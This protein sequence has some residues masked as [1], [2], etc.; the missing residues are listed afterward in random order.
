MSALYLWYMLRF[1]F[2]LHFRFWG[3]CAEHARQLHRYTHS[4][5][6]CFLSPFHPHLAFLPMLSLPNLPTHPLSLPWLPAINSCVWCS[7]PYV[8][9]F[10]LFNTCLWV[11]TRSVWFSVLVLVCWERWF[12]GASMSL[13][14]TQ[15]HR[16]WWMH[17]IPWCICATFSLFSLSWMGI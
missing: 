5:V 17:N 2:L 12:P 13:Q 16:F 7:P 10:S 1:F 15:T 3:T 11:R 14:R 6:F 4:S 9:V 8:H